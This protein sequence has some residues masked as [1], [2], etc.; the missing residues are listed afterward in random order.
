MRHLFPAYL[1][2]MIYNSL[3]LPNMNYSLLHYGVQ[4]VTVLSYCKRKL[5]ELSILNY[6]WLIQSGQPILKNMNQ[7]KLLD[8][9]TFHMLK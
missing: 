1:L 6:R 8:L 9:Y 4:F 7:L 2:R 5:F 3:I